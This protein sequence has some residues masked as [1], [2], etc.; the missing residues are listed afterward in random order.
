MCRGGGGAADRILGFN[1]ASTDALAANGDGGVSCPPI[2]SVKFVMAEIA[3]LGLPGTRG[4]GVIPPPNPL[5]SDLSPLAL[6]PRDAIEDEDDGIGDDSAGDADDAGSRVIPLS[7][8]TAVRNI[9]P[10]ASLLLLLLLLLVAS[11]FALFV[12]STNA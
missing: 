10:A 4:E 1:D 5:A 3:V 9:E 8:G 11:P 6:L 12:A 7:P 2:A